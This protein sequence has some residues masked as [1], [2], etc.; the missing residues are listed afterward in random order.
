MPFHLRPMVQADI[1]AVFAIEMSAHRAPWGRAVLSDCVLVGYDCRILEID[2]ESGAELLSYVI[3]RYEEGICHIL[4]LCVAPAKQGMGYGEK[5]LQHVIDIQTVP[6]IFAIRLEVRPSNPHA[7]RLY[8]KLG[9]QQI[10]VKRGYYREGEAIEDAMV[11][12]KTLH[13]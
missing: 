2:S 4:N 5:M 9:F 6:G 7:I 12:E 13:R 10:A 8:E 1:D 11:L 3:N